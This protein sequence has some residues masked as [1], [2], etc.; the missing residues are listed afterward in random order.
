MIVTISS[1]SRLNNPIHRY[2]NIVIKCGLTIII[3]KNGRPYNINIIKNIHIIIHIYG[4]RLVSDTRVTD[5]EYLY[6]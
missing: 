3:E 1:C 5:I 2:S 6:T 4:V